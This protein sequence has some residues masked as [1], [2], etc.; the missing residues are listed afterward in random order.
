ML[1]PE[2]KEER[3]YVRTKKGKPWWTAERKNMLRHWQ[4]AATLALIGSL[5]GGVKLAQMWMRRY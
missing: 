4:W 1:S 5:I 3:A 2:E